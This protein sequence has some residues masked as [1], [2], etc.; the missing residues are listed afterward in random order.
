MLQ[1]VKI[2]HIKHIKAVYFK[3]FYEHFTFVCVSPLYMISNIV[4]PSM[5]HKI[6]FVKVCIG[7]INLAD[8][9]TVFYI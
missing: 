9:H 1:K 5:L 2:A 8:Y 4:S 7:G 6:S 3:C